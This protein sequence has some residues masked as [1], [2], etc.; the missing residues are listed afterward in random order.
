MYH[1]TLQLQYWTVS[2]TALLHLRFFPSKLA[3]QVKVKFMF[4]F[5]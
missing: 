1:N 3:D 5:H 2:N 4:L